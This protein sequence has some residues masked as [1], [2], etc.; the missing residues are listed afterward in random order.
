MSEHPGVS[1]IVAFLDA[2]PFL[3][4]AI[5]S[6]LAQ[7]YPDWELVL[8]DDGSTDGSTAIA[9]GYATRFSDRIRYLQHAGGANRGMSA[10]RNAGI[11]AA[12]GELLAFI[13]ADDVWERQKL[14]EQVAILELHPNAAMVLGATQWWYSWADDA[15]RRD[16]V[17]GL[18]VKTEKLVPPPRLLVPLLRNEAPT[19]TPALIRRSALARAGGFADGFRG[20]YEDQVAFVKICVREP[21][22]VAGECWYRWRQHPGSACAVSVRSGEYAGARARFLDW[23]DEYLREEGIVARDVWAALEHE[24]RRL[25]EPENR[26]IARRG[27]RLLRRV[28]PRRAAVPGRP[29]L[30]DAQSTVPISRSWGFERGLPIDRYY[31]ERFLSEHSS[32]IV[33]SVLE[34]GDDVYTRRFGGD[35]VTHVDVL[36]ADEGNPKSTIV[37]DL[38]AADDLGSDLYDCIVFTQTLQ[39]I[40]D[41]RAAVRTLHR[42]LRPEGVLLLTVPGTTQS[43][44]DEFAD[45]WYWSFTTR[46]VHRLL[47]EVFAENDFEV[48]AHGNVLAAV[49][50]LHGLAVEDLQQ[51]DVERGDPDYE[52]VVAA[53]A[54]KGAET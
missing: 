38:S 28:G 54:V 27:R 7:T 35:R 20:M 39:F 6:V 43:G 47:R 49:G 17:R 2:E 52:V 51:S 48:E 36:H 23:L 25:H 19:V 12:T 29:W 22:F 3:A 13:D 37:A 42:L 18:G 14:E 4:E 1:V 53:R 33:G 26:S 41:V 34:V 32:D 16:E 24:R 31:I 40:Y 44:P 21:V 11:A 30:G 45:S 9:R 50:L 15:A 46:S 10:S 8:V 5:E